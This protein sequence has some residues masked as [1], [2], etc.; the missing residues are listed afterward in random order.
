MLE[1]LKGRDA[2]ETAENFAILF[3]VIGAGILSSGIGLTIITP[4]GLPAILSMV[5][6]FISFISTVGLI[7][8]WLIRE[9]K[10]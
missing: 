5:G 1:K 9:F 6:A 2:L 7:F 4:K 8:I 3:I 10:E